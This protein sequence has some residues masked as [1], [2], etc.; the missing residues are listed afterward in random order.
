MIGS[1]EYVLR[2]WPYHI[3][4]LAALALAAGFSATRRDRRS[5]LA[6]LLGV[7]VLE[8]GAISELHPFQYLSFVA[9]IVAWGMMLSLPLSVAAVP[10][11]WRVTGS[12]FPWRRVAA[13]FALGI[14]AIPFTMPMEIVVNC[15]LGTDCL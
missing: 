1:V 12:A 7:V 2:E 9:N 6:I 4:G 3:V 13:S 8:S 5:L 11:A 14:L 10:F 15:T